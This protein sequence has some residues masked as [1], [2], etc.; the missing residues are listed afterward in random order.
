MKDIKSYTNK[1]LLLELKN[2]IKKEGVI[3]KSEVEASR[4]LSK[5]YDKFVLTFHDD[6]KVMYKNLR[7]EA[8][9]RNLDVPLEWYKI[10]CTKDDIIDRINEVKDYIIFNIYNNID[11]NEKAF[12]EIYKIDDFFQDIIEVEINK[13]KVIDVNFKKK[14]KKSI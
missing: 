7:L 12:M 14:K 10:E 8:L 6:I 5:Y 1:E 2:I 3:I 4:I 11:N 13:T 9:K